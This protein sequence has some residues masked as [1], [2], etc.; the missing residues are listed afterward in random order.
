MLRFKLRN[1]GFGKKENKKRVHDK[2]MR[3][4]AIEELAKNVQ[5]AIEDLLT[6]K[7]SLPHS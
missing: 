7:S 5:Q 2:K 3:R 4:L 1:C 6:V